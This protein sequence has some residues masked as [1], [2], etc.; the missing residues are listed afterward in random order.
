MFTHSEYVISQK[1]V[2]SRIPQT[3]RV[4]NP[5]QGGGGKEGM[6]CGGVN[7]CVHKCMRMNTRC[8]C[9]WGREHE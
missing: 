4:G 7:A 3:F 6:V 5:E 1:A 8:L 9:E 2:K